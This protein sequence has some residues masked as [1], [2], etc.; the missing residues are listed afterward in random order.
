V[1]ASLAPDEARLL[2][3][4]FRTALVAGP[5]DD[6]REVLRSLCLRCS[7]NFSLRLARHL[8]EQ[9]LG[10][11]SNAPEPAPDGTPSLRNICDARRGGQRPAPAEVRAGFTGGGVTQEEADKML[12]WLEAMLTVT[13]HHTESAQFFNAV[14]QLAPHIERLAIK[15]IVAATEEPGRSA[16]LLTERAMRVWQVL[17]IARIAS[18]VG[19]FTW[20]SKERPGGVPSGNKRYLVTEG[21]ARSEPSLAD[22]EEL[23]RARKRQREGGL[24]G[25]RVPHEPWTDVATVLNL[26]SLCISCH[27]EQSVEPANLAGVIQK[28]VAWSSDARGG[29]RYSEGEA[30]ACADTT[31]HE[32]WQE[33]A[34]VVQA[35]APS[36]EEGAEATAR[37]GSARAAAAALRDDAAGDGPVRQMTA[38]EYRQHAATLLTELTPLPSSSVDA[39]S[40]RQPHVKQ[41]P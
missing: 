6:W 26:E 13:T 36:G 35:S 2:G 7:D 10:W 33:E 37:E 41:G 20:L 9:A 31:P 8:L 25:A 39:R 32:S 3:R 22:I 15:K 21:A 11:S 27:P 29:D 14:V 17:G 4:I 16:A 30:A 34:T 24:S 23:V 38:A 28:W 40:Q 18:G 12:H 1:L 5:S 19:F